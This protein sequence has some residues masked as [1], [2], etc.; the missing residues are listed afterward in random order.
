MIKKAKAGR[1]KST[2]AEAAKVAAST[3]KG[4]PS[5]KSAKSVAAT[6]LM[7]KPS[8]GETWRI[9]GSGSARTVRTTQSSVQV[10]DKAVT[11]YA[12][13]LKRLADK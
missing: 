1:A 3:L 11:K 10:M 5:A 9:S 12:K 8:K 2:G 13:A 6:A 7:K 4:K